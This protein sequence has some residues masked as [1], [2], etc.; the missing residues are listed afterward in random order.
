MTLY[1]I[2]D[3][4]ISQGKSYDHATALFSLNNFGDI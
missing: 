1:D 3:Y 4:Y 2:K